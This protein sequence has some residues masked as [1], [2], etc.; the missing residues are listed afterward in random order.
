MSIKGKKT[1]HKNWAMQ[2]QGQVLPPC[3]CIAKIDV[4]D[5]EEAICCVIKAGGGGNVISKIGRGV[6][7]PHQNLF[8]CFWVS[9]LEAREAPLKKKQSE[10][11]RPQLRLWQK[12]RVNPT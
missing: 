2:R 9:F 3:R 5:T 10:T 11:A 8:S 6:C 7:L 1:Q 4:G 12:I